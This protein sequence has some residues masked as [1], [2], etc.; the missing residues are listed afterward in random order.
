[1][2]TVD[3]PIHNKMFRDGL[4]LFRAEATSYNKSKTTILPIH[5]MLQARVESGSHITAKQFRDCNGQVEWRAVRQA[6]SL[7]PSNHWSWVSSPNLLF[8]P[9]Q[10]SVACEEIPHLLSNVGLFHTLAMQGAQNKI[11][12]GSQLLLTHSSLWV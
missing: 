8:C 6:C 1:M 12:H 2:F 5:M 7:L 3:H 11:K 4:F 10:C 9:Y